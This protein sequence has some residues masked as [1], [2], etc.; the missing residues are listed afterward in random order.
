MQKARRERAGP[1]LGCPLT[2]SPPPPARS[3]SARAPSPR[4]C[5][6]AAAAPRGARAGERSGDGQGGDTG[7]RRGRGT[8]AGEGARQGEIEERNVWER[9]R[10]A[11]VKRLRGGPSDSP[12]PPAGLGAAA[13]SDPF[14]P[15][16]NQAQLVRTYPWG[17]RRGLRS[18]AVV[19]KEGAGW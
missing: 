15:H 13:R 6:S 10:G 8:P 12:K 9:S 2:G 16:P 19:R 7:D 3:R 14:P 11:E 4:A 5:A 1:G 18:K 17:Y